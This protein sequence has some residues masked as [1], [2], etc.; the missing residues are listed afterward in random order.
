MKNGFNLRGLAAKALVQT[1]ASLMIRRL[2]KGKACILNFHGVCQEDQSLR[3]LDQSLFT[4]LPLFRDICRHLSEEYQVMPPGELVAL[5]KRGATLPGNAVAITFDDGYESNYTLAYPVL[6]EFCL[7][8]AVFVATGFV[9]GDAPLW[10]HR[11]EAALAMTGRPRLQIAWRDWDHDLRLGT[12]DQRREALEV[13]LRLIKQLPTATA[14]RVVGQ[15][16]AELEAP[17]PRVNQM[18][19]PLRPLSWAQIR[20]MA[21]GGLIEF[22]AHTHRHPILARCT[23]QRAREEVFLSRNRLREELGTMPRLFAYPNGGE[24]DYTG[25]T[26]QIVWEAG[27]QGSFTTRP[28]FVSA[29]CDLLALPRFGAPQSVQEAE[30]TASGAYQTMKDYRT[31]LRSVFVA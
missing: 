22:G 23:T 13:L 6:S 21:R 19:E 20:E 2:W 30:A 9:E 14:E 7:P 17:S 31:R 24:C 3:L 4:P 5:I 10:F 27:F 29:D 16:E 12:H 25:E 1:G 18:P 15:I 28:A 26:R 11:L 8:A